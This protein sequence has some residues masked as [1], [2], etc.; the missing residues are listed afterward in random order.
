MLQN[1]TNTGAFTSIIF[2][3]TLATASSSFIQPSFANKDY[4]PHPTYESYESSKTSG[5]TIAFYS[6]TSDNFIRSISMEKPVESHSIEMQLRHKAVEESFLKNSNGF[7][8]EKKEYFS[9]LSNSIC[10]LDFKD[11]ISLYNEFDNSIDT[12]IKLS[13]GLKLSISQFL[14]EEIEASA[15]FSIHREKNLLI[16]DEMP[17]YEIVN[18]INSVIAKLVNEH[19]A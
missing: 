5:N 15:V 8:L 19:E 17:I 4:S 10:K 12:V 7:P 1:S 2:V 6:H 11:S 9:L 16:S 13:N 14:D 3:A 18:T